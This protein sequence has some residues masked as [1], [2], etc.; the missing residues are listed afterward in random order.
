[1]GLNMLSTHQDLIF[2]EFK[3]ALTTMYVCIPADLLL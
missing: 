1:M 2:V 3:E